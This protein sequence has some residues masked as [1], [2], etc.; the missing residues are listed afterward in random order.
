MVID[1]E[2]AHLTAPEGVVAHLII[3]EELEAHLTAA[4]RTKL[5][6]TKTM[7]NSVQIPQHVTRL[8]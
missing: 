6:C 4:N 8:I 5:L 1:E 7:E 2:A 3:A